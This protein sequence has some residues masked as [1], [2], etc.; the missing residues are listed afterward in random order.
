MN[1]PEHPEK[2][3]DAD[4][5]WFDRLT[6]KLTQASD[7]DALREAEALRSAILREQA[8]EEGVLTS[9]D[10]VRLQSEEEA[11]A[12]RLLFALRREG[13]ITAASQ[14]STNKPVKKSPWMMPSA[15]A[16]SVLVGFLALQALQ[17]GAVSVQ[18]DE[19]PVMRGEIQT[20]LVRD[21]APQKRADAIAAKLKAT[22]LTARQ[23][24]S[25]EKFYV[26]TDL[27]AEKL[28]DAAA[29]LKELGLKDRVG[30]ARIEII[31]P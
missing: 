20:V 7:R 24:Q 6:G 14:A 23:Y 27:I 25:G 21:A 16:A 4:Q 22:G 8:K 9:D 1:P 17:F 15:L 13:L 26:D 30:Q 2:F 3:S 28:E 19:P 11:G 5:Q 10:S 12:Q 31:K 29:T 18:Y